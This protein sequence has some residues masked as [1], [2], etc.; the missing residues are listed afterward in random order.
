M[1]TR[2]NALLVELVYI[3]VA[4][5]CLFLLA[6]VM[7]LH[8]HTLTVHLSVSVTAPWRLLLSP[9]RGGEGEAMC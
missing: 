8:I 2:F 7:N 1:R 6:R 4:S 5:A 3:H 9:S